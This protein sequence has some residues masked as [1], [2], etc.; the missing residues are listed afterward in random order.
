MSA[1]SWSAKETLRL[2]KLQG[3]SIL[4]TLPDQIYDDI[5]ELTAYICENSNGLGYAS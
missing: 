2:A 4:D 5:V 1:V 3:Y